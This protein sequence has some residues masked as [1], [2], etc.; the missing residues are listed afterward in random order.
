MSIISVVE[1]IEARVSAV[2]SLLATDASGDITLVNNVLQDTSTLILTLKSQVSAL[3]A[4]A[5][6]ATQP[7]SP[8]PAS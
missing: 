5:T 7:S 6:G 8:T 1:Q 2:S 3:A 4:A